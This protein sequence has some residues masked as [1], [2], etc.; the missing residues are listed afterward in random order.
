M[1]G[2]SGSPGLENGCG[3]GKHRRGSGT[4]GVRGLEVRSEEGS[5]AGNG[6]TREELQ[7]ESRAGNGEAREELQEESRAEMLYALGS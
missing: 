6:E 5:R 2:V 1:V 4:A 7:E 3:A